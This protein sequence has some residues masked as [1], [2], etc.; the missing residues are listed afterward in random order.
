MGNFQPQK[1]NHCTENA[2]CISCSRKNVPCTAK[3]GAIIAALNVWK[4]PVWNAQRWKLFKTKHGFDKVMECPSSFQSLMNFESIAG[5]EIFW[6]NWMESWINC[7]GNCG[8]ECASGKGLRER[9]PAGTYGA[10]RGKESEFRF[11]AVRQLSIRLFWNFRKRHTSGMW[12]NHACKAKVAR[13]QMCRLEWYPFRRKRW[14]QVLS[15]YL[16]SCTNSTSA[17][18]LVFCVESLPHFLGT[19]W[20]IILLWCLRMSRFWWITTQK[21]QKNMENWHRLN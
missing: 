17:P 10:V 6:G 20:K 11:I 12:L 16:A 14:G 19:F 5:W 13:C 1:R 4:I 8:R 7:A 21:K 15:E 9:F 18:C 2:A 3:G